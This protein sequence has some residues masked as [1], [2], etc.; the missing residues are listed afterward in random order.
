MDNQ[1]ISRRGFALGGAAAALSGAGADAREAVSSLPYDL[2][3]PEDNVALAARVKGSQT[4]AT[5]YL[6]YF[7]EIFEVVPGRVQQPLFRLK[8]IAKS[9][10]T[11]LSEHEY[12]FEN[13]DH[14]LFC[15]KETGEVLER[16]DN[17]FTGEENVPLHYKSGPLK[18]ALAPKDERGRAYLL[19][20][21]LVGD[22]LSLTETSAGE[23]EAYLDPDL[24][25]A[26]STGPT[27]QFMTSSTYFADLRD[28]AKREIPAVPADHTWSFVAPFPAWML[29]G[30]RPGYVLWV[31]SGR[32]VV[33]EGELSG[34]LVADIERNI[35]NFFSA[36]RPWQDRLN[37]W[38][39][40]AKE[41]KPPSSS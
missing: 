6:Q 17:P 22:Q 7:G 36:E 4:D 29:M 26:A 2:D 1:R 16:F 31:W 11:R 19:P 13:Y 24:W 35:P 12:E 14:G 25:G 15:D 27:M 40:Y 37:G 41:R 10:W 30:Q 38:L 21:R 3:R 39:Q 33:D 5:T 9:R 32:K 23:R 8:G 34:D 18:G 28:I 20:W